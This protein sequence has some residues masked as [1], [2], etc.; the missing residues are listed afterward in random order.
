MYIYIIYN[1][2]YSI[3]LALIYITY[4]SASDWIIIKF[5]IYIEAK[6]ISNIAIILTQMYGRYNKP[7]HM[8]IGN[9]RAS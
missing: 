3:F 1:T 7:A 8:F 4:L 9:A 5:C 2:L 6:Y